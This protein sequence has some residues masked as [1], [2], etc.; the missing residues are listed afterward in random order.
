MLKNDLKIYRFKLSFF[1]F[2]LHQFVYYAQ[3]SLKW[4]KEIKKEKKREYMRI[5]VKN[6]EIKIYIRFFLVF[7]G[8]NAGFHGKNTEKR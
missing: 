7:Y 8:K 2:C 1:D 4:I 3:F 5:D 6:G